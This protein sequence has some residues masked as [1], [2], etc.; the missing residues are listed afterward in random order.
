MNRNIRSL[1]V[2]AV[3]TATLTLVAQDTPK[4]PREG[5]RP[6]GPEGRPVIPLLASLD[7]DGDREISAD[8]IAQAAAALQKLD[9]NGDGK[10][11]VNEYRGERPTGPAGAGHG[12]GRR[13]PKE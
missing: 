1:I 2:I 3:G 4:G 10:L 7:A 12:G 6:G 9:K 13:A 8:E 5:G 11:T